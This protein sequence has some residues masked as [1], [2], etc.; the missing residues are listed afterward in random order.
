[1]KQLLQKQVRYPTRVGLDEESH[2]MYVAARYMND[3]HFV[4]IYDYNV[5]TGR[6]TFTEKITKLDMVT[7]M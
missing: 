4:F 2:T 7:V 1:M 6:K 3:E 5:L